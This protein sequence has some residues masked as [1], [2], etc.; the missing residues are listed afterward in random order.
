MTT[1]SVA[2]PATT[3]PVIS[4]N[5][6]PMVLHPRVVTGAGGG[7]DKTILNSPRFLRQLGYDS[8]CLY[9]RPPADSGFDA[10]R[11]RAKYWSAPL[12][13]ID[14]RGATDW[15]IVPKALEVCRRLNVKVWHGHDYKTNLLGLLL[16]RWHPMRLVSTVHGW[17]RHTSRT[18]LYYKLDKWS[19]RFYDQVLCVSPDLLDQCR[20]FG[21]TAERSQLI[22][23]AIDT[24]QFKRRQTPADAKQKLG[25]PTDKPLIG[26]VGRLSPEKGF[27]RLIHCVAALH[28]QGLRPSLAIIGDGDEH[29]YLQSVIDETGIS[30]HVKLAGFQSNTVDWYEAM[31]VFALSSLREGLPNVILEAM[32]LGTPVVSTKVAGVPRV[33]ENEKSGLIV[34]I[35][36]DQ[37]LT[38]ALGRV[39]NDADLRAQF[40]KEG[41]HVVESRYSFANRMEKIAAVYDRLES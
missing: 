12:E 41:R 16:K 7:P 5:L 23:N 36:N 31:D 34:P 9:L 20:E 22:E 40:V 15:R 1:N 21:V 18:P 17:V 10:L 6:G 24:E 11:Q 32:A 27:D 39:L 37:E 35:G 33:I 29:N 25:L 3:G 8:A 26:A 4:E 19:L 13:E 30:D 2:E 38:S 14:D 28:Q